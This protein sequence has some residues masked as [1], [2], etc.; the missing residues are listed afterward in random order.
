VIYVLHDAKNPELYGGLPK[1]PTIPLAVSLWKTPL[2]WIG[3]LAIV[4][5]LMG[6]AVHYLRFGPKSEE[7]R[8]SSQ[9]GEK[10]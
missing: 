2:K 4:G 5:G 6:L 7:S 9:Q 10:R 1:N 8:D 3:N